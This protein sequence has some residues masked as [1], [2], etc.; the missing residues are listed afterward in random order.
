MKIIIEL[1]CTSFE[2]ARN[3]IVGPGPVLSTIGE[4]LKPATLHVGAEPPAVNRPNVSPG[5]PTI[6]KIGAKAKHSALAGVGVGAFRNNYN[7]K[8]IEHLRLLWDRGEVKF[9]G[10]DFY[11]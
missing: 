7:G 2:D 4:L 10:K 3:Q 6:T 8:L 9:D 5:A 11:K 1:D